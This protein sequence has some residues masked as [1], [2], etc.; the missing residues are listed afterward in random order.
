[1]ENH[2]LVEVKTENEDA[3]ETKTKFEIHVKLEPLDEELPESCSS[4]N[5][6]SYES[7]FVAVKQETYDDQSEAG[8][9]SVDT[10]TTVADFRESKVTIKVSFA[11]NLKHLHS[12]E[13][14]PKWYKSLYSAFKH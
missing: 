11:L 6:S 8:Q 3:A 14:A 7:H 2:G 12:L 5:E 4:A 1:M 13:R 9:S 10:S